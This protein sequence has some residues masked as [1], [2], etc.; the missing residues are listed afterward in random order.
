MPCGSGNCTEQGSNDTGAPHA[1]LSPGAQACTYQLPLLFARGFTIW[2]SPWLVHTDWTLVFKDENTSEISP[3]YLGSP[4]L[5]DPKFE[6]SWECLE[7][8]RNVMQLTLFATHHFSLV[9][10]IL[11]VQIIMRSRITHAQKGTLIISGFPELCIPYRPTRHLTT[12][13]S[14]LVGEAVVFDFNLLCFI[15]LVSARVSLS[16]FFLRAVSAMQSNTVKWFT[17]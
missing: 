9:F 7:P 1:C 2:V 17:V 11:P 4:Y 14:W 8:S 16:Y 10:R 12:V 13:S 15:S 5:S 6:I 3:V